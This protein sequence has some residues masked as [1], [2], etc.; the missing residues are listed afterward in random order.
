[1]S[2]ITTLTTLDSHHRSLLAK[3]KQTS[4]AVVPW[5]TLADLQEPDTEI[6]HANVP[7]PRPYTSSTY[8]TPAS[9]A[10]HDIGSTAWKVEKIVEGIV[11]KKAVEGMYQKVLNPY[12]PS[13]DTVTGYAGSVATGTGALISGV[14]DTMWSTAASACSATIDAGSVFA[15]Q[16][17]GVGAD[18]LSAAGDMTRSYG[19]YA[20]DAAS[21]HP[22]LTG[23]AL[24]GTLLG[25]GL[26]YAAGSTS[27]V[28]EEKAA[29][30][31]GGRVDNLWS[32]L[33]GMIPGPSQSQL[34]TRI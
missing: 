10:G 15:G 28:E 4:S 26:Y 27:D 29:K 19:E 24:A 33:S 20:L 12:L 23:L 18:V 14:A 21:H 2:R 6:T 17:L 31:R 5:Q 32:R 8:P 34:L 1:M 22:G 9:T 30:T 13:V 16:A 11:L 7:S 3:P 25:A